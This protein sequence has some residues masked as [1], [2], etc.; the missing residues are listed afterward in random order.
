MGYS[1]KNDDVLAIHGLRSGAS[2][3]KPCE[4]AQVEVS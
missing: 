4:L 2:Y 1:I 3:P